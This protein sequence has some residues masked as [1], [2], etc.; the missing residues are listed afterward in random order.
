MESTNGLIESQQDGMNAG[1]N[2]Q[3]VQNNLLEKKVEEG[4]E[5]EIKEQ[6]NISNEQVTSSDIKVKEN[7]GNNSS[8]DAKVNANEN[9]GIN[10]NANNDKSGKEKE[11]E[12]INV[13]V[14]VNVNSNIVEQ[15]KEKTEANVNEN[16]ELKLNENND[17]ELKEI[18]NINPNEHNIIIK[19]N[20]N[21]NIIETINMKINETSSPKIDETS[22]NNLDINPNSNNNDNI[23]LNLP[24]ETD[25]LS[26]N[27]LSTSPQFTTV[28]PENLKQKIETEA[29]PPKT[30]KPRTQHK[31]RSITYSDFYEFPKISSNL[32]GINFLGEDYFLEYLTC[33]DGEN[34]VIKNLNCFVDSILQVNKVL[35]EN[36]ITIRFIICEYT[37]MGIFFQLL[38]FKRSDNVFLQT[39]PFNNILFITN[40]ILDRINLKITTLLGRILSNEKEYD[41]LQ[42]V[43]ILGQTFYKKQEHET[44]ENK[45]FNIMSKE[46][47]KHHL[48][49]EYKTWEKLIEYHIKKQKKNLKKLKQRMTKEREKTLAATT[50]VTYLFNMKNFGVD[51]SCVD[52]IKKFAEKN[53]IPK[54]LIESNFD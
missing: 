7:E 23:I 22:T 2:E 24:K 47:G 18:P 28:L 41:L 10:M 29:I 15:I 8:I 51:E 4:I 40:K 48:F 13:N 3:H 44:E 49:Q 26:P 53:E 32:R 42:Y 16:N 1:S 11:K 5:V 25:P 34:G 50:I 36:F 12:S 43:V 27:E 20:E 9:E 14:N 37:F 45:Y 39:E 31:R 30:T 33:L 54:E 17:L 21:T 6:T 46:L 35:P 52:N 38:N 19:E